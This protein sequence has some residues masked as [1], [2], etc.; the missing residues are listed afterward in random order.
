MANVKVKYYER[1]RNKRKLPS[2]PP[3]LHCFVAFSKAESFYKMCFLWVNCMF[4]YGFWWESKPLIALIYIFICFFAR[5]IQSSCLCESQIYYKRP[6]SWLGGVQW[7]TLSEKLIAPFN[8]FNLPGKRRRKKKRW[9]EMESKKPLF[10]S[11]GSEG[12]LNWWG[13]NPGW[14]YLW[15]LQPEQAEGD[16]LKGAS[17]I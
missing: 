15:D 12:N 16:N 14:C 11:N 9:N 2:F 5:K 3:L 1:S 10:D 6:N 13:K 7:N 8:L 4:I 17:L